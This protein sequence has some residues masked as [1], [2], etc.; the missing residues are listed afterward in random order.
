M[1]SNTCHIVDK[2]KKCSFQL[3]FEYYVEKKGR[4]SILENS[5]L[6]EF[7]KP[8]EWDLYVKMKC[9][10][11]EFLFRIGMH[12]PRDISIGNNNNLGF[13]DVCFLLSLQHSESMQ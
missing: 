8:V 13:L 6:L 7:E 12:V 1:V 4:N 9:R 11:P 10:I 2:C 3:K 5:T